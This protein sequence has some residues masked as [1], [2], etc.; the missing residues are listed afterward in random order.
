MRSSNARA[1][2][3][4][5]LDRWTAGARDHAPDSKAVWAS[6]TVRWTSSELAASTLREL[7]FASYRAER[8][9]L[10]YVQMCKPVAGFVTESLERER[11]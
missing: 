4:R 9:I 5:T 1:R 3:V 10:T 2:R 7:A 11:E 6:S 8:G